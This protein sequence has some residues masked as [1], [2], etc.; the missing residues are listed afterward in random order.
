MKTITVILFVLLAGCA[1]RPDPYEAEFDA[2]KAFLVQEH[3]KGNLTFADA[4]LLAQAK[5]NELIARRSAATANSLGA[6]SLGL[7]GLQV[8][9]QNQPVYV[10]PVRCQ[11]VR[12]GAFLN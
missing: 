1:T 12:Q 9:Q 7:Q 6:M 10:P 2:Y 11:T 4:L 3:N 5:Q 8:M